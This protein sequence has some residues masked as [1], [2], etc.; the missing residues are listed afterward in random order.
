MIAN[1]IKGSISVIGSGSI[2]SETADICERLGREIANTGYLLVCGGMGGVMRA[3]CKGCKETGGTTMG[4]LPVPR[5]NA[6]NE[7]LDIIIPTNL[8]DGRNL[9]VVLSGD[10]VIA[11][12]GMSGT[13]TELSYAWMYNKPIVALSQVEGWSSKL[14]GKKIDGRRSDTINGAD[15][16]EDAVKLLLTLIK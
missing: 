4:I 10:G 14:I 3:V 2:D 9:L 16:P 12:G 8:G 5:K 7:Y 13:L 1:K 15:T 6:G 11:V